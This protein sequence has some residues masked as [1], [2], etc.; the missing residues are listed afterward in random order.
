[1]T[2]KEYL[3]KAYILNERINTKIRQLD[4]LN[5]MATHITATIDDMPKAPCGDKSKFE[6]TVIKIIEMQ[7]K[8]N[9]QIDELVDIKA[10]LMA[11]IARVPDITERE[12]LEKRYINMDTWSEMSDSMYIGLRRLYQIHGNALCTIEGILKKDGKI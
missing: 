3:N 4:E 11:V 8:I 12:V 1:M 7:E 2:V 9:A 10:E 5:D 6:N